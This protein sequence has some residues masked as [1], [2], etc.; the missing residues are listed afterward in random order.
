MTVLW[1]EVFV[2]LFATLVAFGLDRERAG[3]IWAVGGAGMLACIVAA[4]ALRVPRVGVILGSLVQVLLILAGLAIPM[5][6]FIGGV[7]AVTWIIALW[8]GAR[9]DR[10][11]AERD[12]LEA[13]S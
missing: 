11:R 9:I 4:G 10:E 12:A 1:L 7:F 13:S 3:T 8:L 6:W 5:M 2:V